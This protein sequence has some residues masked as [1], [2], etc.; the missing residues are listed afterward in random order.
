MTSLR[1][2]LPPDIMQMIDAALSDKMTSGASLG[3]PIDKDWLQEDGKD[4]AWYLYYFPDDFLAWERLN[5]EM[6]AYLENED[7][8]E[9]MMWLPGGFG[10]SSVLLRWMIKV[11]CKE[12]NIS[13][14]F[15]EKTEPK[16]HERAQYL[17]KVL[18]H[19]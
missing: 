14:I 6:I 16:S 11:M 9:V 18:E 4:A 5:E 19:N 3:M 8:P 15:I 13:F 1:P 10:K 12:H 2:K 7:I 17:M